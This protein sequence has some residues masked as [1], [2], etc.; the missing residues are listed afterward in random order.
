MIVR[1]LTL[2]L[3]ALCIAIV[4][5]AG[6][7]GGSPRTVI[8]R[9]VTPFRADGH[10]RSGLRV[11]RAT[12][13]TCGPGSDVLPND[14]YRC[15]FDHSVVDPCWR[16][17]RAAVPA[18]VCLGAPWARTVIRLRSTGALPRSSGRTNLKAEPWGITLRSGTRC[19]A[20][21]GAHD[22]VTGREGAAV[23]DYYCSGTLAL[24][25]GIDRSHR[26]W[27]IRAARITHRPAHPYALL[28]R[29]AIKTAWFGGNNPRSRHH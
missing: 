21:Q 22:T 2:T 11:V 9:D 24:V 26:V 23:V 5:A 28:G 16:E 6:A 3:L 15:S 1:C 27:T 4:P 18:V 19:L 29:V 7:A 20:F 13:G 8:V 14:V 12:D 25:R 10:L 17:A